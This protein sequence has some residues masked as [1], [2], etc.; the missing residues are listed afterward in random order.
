MARDYGIE[1]DVYLGDDEEE[2]YVAAVT[3]F[4]PGDPGQIWGPPERCWPPEPPEIEWELR[5]PDGKAAPAVVL[6]EQRIDS[7]TQELMRKALD[8]KDD[9]EPDHDQRYRYA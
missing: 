6:S 7:I 3:Y 1:L 8:E 9:Y 4:F 2:H 5:N